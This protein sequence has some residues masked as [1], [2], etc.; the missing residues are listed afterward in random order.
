M[1]QDGES[2]SRKGEFRSAIQ[3]AME[4]DSDKKLV[5]KISKKIMLEVTVWQNR[6]LKK[7]HSFIFMDTIHYKVYMDDYRYKALQVFTS[8]RSHSLQ[9]LTREKQ[10]FTN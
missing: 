7:V 3:N 6:P 4:M 9:K 8:A 10:R 2:G 5:S 1:R